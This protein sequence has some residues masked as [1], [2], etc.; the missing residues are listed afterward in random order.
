MRILVYKFSKKQTLGITEAAGSELWLYNASPQPFKLWWYAAMLLTL[1]SSLGEESMCL[2]CATDGCLWK[3][4]IKSL[5][6]D[7]KKYTGLQHR[8]FFP[9]PALT[10]WYY[11]QLTAWKIGVRQAFI[12]AL[13]KCRYAGNLCLYTRKGLLNLNRYLTFEGRRVDPMAAGRKH[14]FFLLVSW[15]TL[16]FVFSTTLAA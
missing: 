10:E 12:C 14:C 15:A 7:A 8:L 1:W 3:C 6:G 16:I 4:L 5:G 13:M 11:I 9:L 2:L